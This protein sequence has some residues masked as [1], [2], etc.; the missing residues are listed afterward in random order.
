MG[1]SGV[2]HDLRHY[3]TNN[4]KQLFI[5]PLSLLR[6]SDDLVKINQNSRY[7]G[8]LNKIERL[9]RLDKEK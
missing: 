9:H 1:K 2:N 7:L 6:P 8:L 5:L 4:G 3:I